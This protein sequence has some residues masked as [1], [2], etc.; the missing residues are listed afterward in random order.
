[1]PSLFV[2]FMLFLFFFAMVYWHFFP[3][4]PISLRISINTPYDLQ[5]KRS[6]RL[7]KCFA[8]KFLVFF[9]V[10]MVATR[11]FFTFFHSK[12]FHLNENWIACLLTT[13]SKKK[14]KK[15]REAYK[16]LFIHISRRIYLLSVMPARYFS[17]TYLL[18]INLVEKFPE[19]LMTNKHMLCTHT[20]IVYIELRVTNFI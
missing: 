12:S 10:T 3:T 14:G 16:Q 1:M 5:F 13:G 4:V 2:T 17:F 15:T 8:W 11:F 18:Y 7:V 19:E 20:F 9:A 6:K